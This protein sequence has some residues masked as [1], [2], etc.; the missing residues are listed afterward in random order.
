MEAEKIDIKE[1]LNQKV[2]ETEYEMDKVQTELIKE[3]KVASKKDSQ[4]FYARV[5]NTKLKTKMKESRKDQAIPKYKPGIQLICY[6]SKSI[7][8]TNLSLIIH[9]LLSYNKLY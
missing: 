5:T 4:L 9:L 6:L 1:E 7:H 3:R 2:I 8:S